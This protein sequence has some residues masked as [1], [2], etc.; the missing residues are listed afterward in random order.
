MANIVKESKAKI[1]DF[2]NTYDLV[3]IED[4]PE[5]YLYVL[6]KQKADQ[7]CRICS[8]CLFMDNS[9]EYHTEKTQYTG[10]NIG[11]PINLGLSGVIH[12]NYLEEKFFVSEIEACH[13]AK[14]LSDNF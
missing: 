1:F 14:I 12:A 3:V 10:L 9:H 8:D 2:N 11:Y 6:L 5:G 4:Y 7:I 13:L